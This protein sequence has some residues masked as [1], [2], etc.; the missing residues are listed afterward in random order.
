MPEPF[1]DQEAV[2]A[3]YSELLA[4]YGDDARAV[5]WENLH[6]QIA[7]FYQIAAAQGLESGVSILDLGCG[8]GHLKSFLDARG[9]AVDY[10]GWDICEPLVTRARQLHPEARFE[11]C[12]ILAEPA[13]PPGKEPFDFVI[14]SGSLTSRLPNHED[15]LAAMLRAMFR[16][17]RRGMVFNLLSWYYAHDN[18][19]AVEH[20][21][22]Y[23]A[24]PERILGFCLELSRQVVID[25]NDLAISFAVYVYKGN[26]RPIE[27][28]IDHLSPGRNFGTKHQ[29]VVDY[30]ESFGMYREL[31]AYLESLEPSAPAYD[32][33][34]LTAFLLGDHERMFAAFNKATEL[35]PKW[36]QPLIH[37][38]VAHM[39]EGATEKA[40]V[41]LERAH[42]AE[43]ENTE[44]LY[45][46]ALCHERVGQNDQACAL[47][48][49]TLAH[50]PAHVQAQAA[51][52]RL[53]RSGSSGA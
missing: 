34:G 24:Q 35:D 52:A 36:A 33:I 45:R 41:L 48:R 47:Y 16:L 15:W 43:P 14:A 40:L 10:T 12:D 4:K 32:R 38:G 3:F 22:Y 23:W 5:G 27:R 20:E 51:L 13:P 46:L 30:Y 11:V 21:R 25:H 42:A 18:P 6:T 39:D 9:L 26:T 29:P 31:I 7:C 28:F 1:A 49:A 2:A 37:L 19:L 8:L 44:V 17:C 50:D 53:A